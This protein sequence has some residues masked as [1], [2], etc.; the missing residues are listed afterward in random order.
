MREI[1]VDDEDEEAGLDVSQHAETAY[2][3]GEATMAR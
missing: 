3:L 2:N 1:D